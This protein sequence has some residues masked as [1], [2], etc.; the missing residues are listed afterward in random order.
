MKRAGM[1]DSAIF[2]IVAAVILL[3]FGHLIINGEKPQR[4][5]V[6]TISR[7]DTTRVDVWPEP[8]PDSTRAK[9][10]KRLIGK[11]GPR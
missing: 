6:L 3:L 5:V 7:G 8:T 11:R 1:V 4:E 9:M 10:L 2:I